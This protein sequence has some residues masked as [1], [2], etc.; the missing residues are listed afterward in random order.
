M[1]GFS[2]MKVSSCSQIV[3]P[4]NTS[5]K[6]PPTSGITGQRFSSQR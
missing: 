1:V 5:T 3:S 2:L 6:K 4:P